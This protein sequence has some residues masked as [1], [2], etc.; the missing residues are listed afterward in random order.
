M[1]NRACH[2]QSP[3][4]VILLEDGVH[5]TAG[6]DGALTAMCLSASYKDFTAHDLPAGRGELCPEIRGRSR[7]GSPPPPPQSSQSYG[8]LGGNLGRTVS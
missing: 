8:G 7:A 6:C 2:H 5:K 4:G 1:K 3:S